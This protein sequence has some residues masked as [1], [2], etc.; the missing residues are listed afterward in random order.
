MED[1]ENLESMGIRAS[2][3]LYLVMRSYCLMIEFFYQPAIPEP[4]QITTK[5]VSVLNELHE[6]TH[7]L[8]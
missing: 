5:S 4:R 1:E 8:C 7:K 3:E 6:D 2:D